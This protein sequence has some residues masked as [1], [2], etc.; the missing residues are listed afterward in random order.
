M[1]PLPRLACLLALLPALASA[2]DAESDL[3]ARMTAQRQQFAGAPAQGAP[4]PP[5][6]P[7][8]SG[9]K[10]AS[11][12][13]LPRSDV[14]GYLAR[15]R[16]T[17]NFCERQ[18]A[19]NDDAAKLYADADLAVRA[20]QDLT[21][22]PVTFADDQKFASIDFFMR[23][24]AASFNPNSAQTA[25]LKSMLDGLIGSGQVQQT[26]LVYEALVAADGNLTMAMG[27]LAQ[28]FCDNRDAYVP[29]VAGMQSADGKN[30]YRFAGFFIGLHKAGT[31][32]A[33]AAASYANIGG[34][35]VIY[36][37]AEVYSAWAGFFSTGHMDGV[38]TLKTLGPEGHGNIVDKGGEL[39]KGFDAAA[40][41]RAARPSAF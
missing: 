20:Y 17:L 29:K 35:P 11:S 18:R 15:T 25:K 32:A 1:A 9:P 3:R 27:S 22:R 23:S 30:Y 26:D 40:S 31:R 7:A 2:Q 28:L 36:A 13:C 10:T 38:D 21:G 39:H 5:A 6:A 24:G 16:D 34:N 12:G 19:S 37:G 14:A 41:M 4:T 33:G 8:A